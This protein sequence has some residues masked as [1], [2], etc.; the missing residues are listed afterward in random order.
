MGTDLNASIGPPSGQGPPFI[1]NESM[2]N[3]NIKSESF[4]NPWTTI[5]RPMNKFME[6]N[7]I[8]FAR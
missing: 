8:Q 2:H 1:G 4:K 7:D 5:P 3:S 6:I